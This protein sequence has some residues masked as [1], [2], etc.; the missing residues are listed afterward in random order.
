MNKRKAYS[1]V[2]DLMCVGSNSY[3]EV[4]SDLFEIWNTRRII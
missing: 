4:E 3:S 1:F 2:S